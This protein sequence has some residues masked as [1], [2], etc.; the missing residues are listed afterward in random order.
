[1]NHSHALSSHSLIQSIMH[2]FSWPQNRYQIPPMLL[3]RSP[4]YII[5]PYFFSRSILYIIS[6][7]GLIFSDI[8]YSQPS[9]R[10]SLASCAVQSPGPRSQRAFSP[11]PFTLVTILLHSL[12]A[13]F[14]RELVSGFDLCLSETPVAT[15]R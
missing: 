9:S 13:E 4:I 8:Q 11:A 14:S 5:R 15:W 12:V 7:R 3:F 10:S 6:L 1:M 2:A